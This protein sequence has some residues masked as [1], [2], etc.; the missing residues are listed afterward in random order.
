MQP[1]PSWLEA[2]LWPG[3]AG[4][5]VRN[6]G[7]V[8]AP[9]M[10]SPQVLHQDWK[11]GGLAHILWRPR[12]ELLTTE[13]ADNRYVA[14]EDVNTHTNKQ[15]ARWFSFVLTVQD[16]V[17]ELPPRQMAPR[18]DSTL[19][20]AAVLLFALLM[21]LCTACLRISNIDDAD[22]RFA[23]PKKKALSNGGKITRKKTDTHQVHVS[24]IV[25]LSTALHRGAANKHTELWATSFSVELASVE[26]QQN[27]ARTEGAP[28]MFTKDGASNPDWTTIA[29]DKRGVP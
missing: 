2:L 29:I 22:C 13:F 4:G 20:M 5:V 27:W 25:F 26:G 15:T 18:R 16:T 6:M 24:S 3:E 1:L 7:W 10:S 12:P 14:A 23:H 11:G 9:P 28:L 8:I 19:L 17:L 21:A